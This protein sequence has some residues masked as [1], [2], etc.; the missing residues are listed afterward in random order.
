MSKSALNMESQLIHNGIKEFSGQ[1]LVI[2]PGWV[3][4][5]MRSKRDEDALL[6]VE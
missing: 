4:T 3:Q 1:V 5:Y 2:H 6:T